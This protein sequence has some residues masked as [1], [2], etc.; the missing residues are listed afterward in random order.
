MLNDLLID[1]TAIHSL[2]R[3]P[4][5]SEDLPR[6]TR[7]LLQ[8]TEQLLLAEKIWICDSVTEETQ[9]QTMEFVDRLTSQGL[10]RAKN[11]GVLRIAR[12]SPAQI[13]TACQLA[14]PRLYELLSNRPPSVIASLMTEESYLLRPS[15]AQPLSYQSL[16]AYRFGTN[17]AL[18]Y[19]SR[20]TAGKGWLPSSAL[21]L[22]NS[23]LYRW[24]RNALRE[25]PDDNDPFWEKFNAMSRW[26][27]NEQLA[28]QLGSEESRTFYAPALGR[29]KLLDRLAT[30][31]W[32]GKLEGLEKSLSK[33]FRED[34]AFLASLAELSP[35]NSTRLPIFGI[36]VFSRL[37]QRPSLEDLVQA[38]SDLRKSKQV[39]NVREYFYQDS[40]SKVYD[41]EID[42]IARDVFEEV[43]R[44]NP[45]GFRTKESPGV[46]KVVWK[47]PMLF[48]L[49]I[50]KAKEFKGS[51]AV[52]KRAFLRGLLRPTQSLLAGVVDEG[53]TFNSAAPLLLEKAKSILC[54]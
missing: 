20:A 13:K 51:T 17:D 45:N 18:S 8:V 30:Q 33:Y 42:D 48:G 43:K 29:A 54:E 9:A 10:V 49:T 23:D 28:V 50:E 3:R 4:T 25:F 21:P 46:W 5:L 19:C 26:V 47:V 31:G 16:S 53:F 6:R 32:V 12:F 36:W 7:E 22:M 24:F 2:K 14:A 37:S 39:A 44:R 35:A 52:E 38:I 41:N 27:F 15:G 1:H 34:P 11:D 40:G